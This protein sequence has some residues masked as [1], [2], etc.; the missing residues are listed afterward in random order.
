MRPTAWWKSRSGGVGRGSGY[1]E[2]AGG[3]E[4]GWRNSFV[5]RRS[6]GGL[7]E[8]PA[9]IGPPFGGNIARS[10][11]IRLSS[12]SS[13]IGSFE[14]GVLPSRYEAVGQSCG[15]AAA[16]AEY[17]PKKKFRTNEVG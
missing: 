5:C 11:S 17:V 14:Y 12:R 10:S 13:S 3:I 15:V 9:G 1:T 7:G 8:A 2:P 4:R 16:S 6:S